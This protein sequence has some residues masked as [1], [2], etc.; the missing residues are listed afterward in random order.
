MP[1]RQRM[2]ARLAAAVEWWLGEGFP[3]GLELLPRR[4]TTTPPAGAAAPAPAAPAPAADSAAAPLD[5]IAARVAGCTLCRLCETRTRTV[6]G[7]GAPRPQILFVGEAPGADE[8]AS[9]RPFV[10]AAGQ[11]LDRIIQNGVGLRREDVFIAN[12]LKCRPPGNR[13]PQPDE[14]AACSPYLEEQIAALQPKVIVALGRH[15]ANHLLRRD[16][17]LSRLRGALH[18]AV[19]LPGQPLVLATY[20]PAYLLRNPAAKA[21][22]WQ[23]I[24]IAMNHLGLA[25]PGRRSG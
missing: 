3:P 13:D 24:Q 14:K 21:D 10:G 2:D 22:C 17:P 12:V 15:A 19:D 1:A 23:D 18:T 6:P 7:E 16:A 5:E 8:D 9:G 25:P 4:A 20:H 11:L